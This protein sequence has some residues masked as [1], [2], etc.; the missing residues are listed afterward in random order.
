[1]LV[2]EGT[3][4]FYQNMPIRFNPTIPIARDGRLGDRL[5]QA[6]Y[7]NFAPRLGIAW[8]PSSK[9]T[10][11]LGAGIF[12]AQDIGNAVFDM[13]RNFV[14]RFQPTESNHNLTWENPIGAN[15]SNPCGTTAPLV[16]ITQPL[17]LVHN[18]DRKTPYVEQYELNIQRQLANPRFSRWV[19]SAPRA[20][21][22]SASATWRTSPFS[23]PRR[24]RS[25]GPFPSSV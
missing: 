3:G 17:V 25:A 2:R 6:D 12:Y 24:W 13:G 16:C 15:G 22:C 21:G 18:Y 14:G 4:D 23:A 8:S 1:M 9:W 11:R 20:T 19:I 10:V 7:T 5:V